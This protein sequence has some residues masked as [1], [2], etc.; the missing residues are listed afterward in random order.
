MVQAF[1]QAGDASNYTI[2]GIRFWFNRL[3][4]ATTTPKRYEGHLDLGNVVEAPQESEKEEVEHFTAK[5]GSRKRDRKV[6]RDISE[7][8]VI[9]LDEPTVENLRHFFQG[10]A[11]IQRPAIAATPPAD[12]VTVTAYALG[13]FVKPTTPNGFYAQAIVAGTSDAGEPTWPTTDLT[14]I[15]DATVTWRMYEDTQ[16]ADEV[17]QLDRTTV[18]ILRRGF[19]AESIVVKDITDVTTFVKDTDYTEVAIIGDW[20]G[21][22]R[23]TTG[24]IADGDLVRVSYDHATRLLERFQ[25]Q[26]SLEVIGQFVLFGVSDTGNEHLRFVNKA[27]IEPEGSFDLDDE[28]FSTFQLRVSILDDSDDNAAEPFGTFDNLGTGA[29]Q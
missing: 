13:D 20:V 14:T 8:V 22:K 2:G 17:M 19:N 25:P 10:G 5:T 16:V 1:T 12:W 24:A 4:D 26:T 9:T 11:V 21:I 3:I 18:R 23:I 15:V 29:D 6:N 27:Q 28:D 7:D